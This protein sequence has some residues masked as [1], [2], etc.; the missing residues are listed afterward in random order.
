LTPR[1][2]GKYLHHR[3]HQWEQGSYEGIEKVIT[4]S[5]LRNR[6]FDDQQVPEITQEPDYARA[7]AAVKT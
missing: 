1:N 4:L 6:D 5:P 2:R 7:V 3:D